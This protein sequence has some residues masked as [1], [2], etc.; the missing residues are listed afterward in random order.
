MNAAAILVARR[1]CLSLSPTRCSFEL[2]L[3][4]LC[5][6]QRA[7]ACIGAQDHGVVLGR[8]SK[9]LPLNFH[10]CVPQSIHDAPIQGCIARR[11]IGQ[12]NTS[13]RLRISSM[14]YLWRCPSRLHNWSTPLALRPGH[15]TNLTQATILVMPVLVA[16]STSLWYAPHRRRGWPEQVRP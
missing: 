6:A 8:T 4:A 9:A 13:K 1:M 5:G 2:R 3:W 14:R 10:V 16:A 15:P 7:C 11:I 12:R